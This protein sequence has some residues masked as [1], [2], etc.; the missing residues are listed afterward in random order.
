MPTKRFVPKPDVVKV[1][2]RTYEVHWLLDVEWKAHG[3]DMDERGHTDHSM[4]VIAVRLE[5]DGDPTHKDGLQEV[6]IH[7][8]MHCCFN[9]SMLWNAWDIINGHKDYGQIDELFTGNGAPLMLSFM[10]DNPDAVKW[11][12]S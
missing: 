4:Q 12:T 5:M 7:E 10:R 8:V 6:F 9:A 1:G 11:V 2:H 3:Y